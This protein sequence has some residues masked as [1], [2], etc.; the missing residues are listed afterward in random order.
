MI[1]SRLLVTYLT[2]QLDSSNWENHCSFL[3]DGM[4]IA[5]KGIVFY[6][7]FAMFLTFVLSQAIRALG[8][9]LKWV[10]P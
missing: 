4:F 8:Y 6:L 9:S 7:I 10:F 1:V 5:S 3:V 2:D